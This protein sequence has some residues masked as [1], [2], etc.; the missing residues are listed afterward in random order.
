LEILSDL[1]VTN[2]DDIG[3]GVSLPSF[4]V[5]TLVM[6]GET[7]IIEFVADKIGAPESFCSTDH[8]EKLE[9]KVI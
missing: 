5:N 3:H 8:G 6:P 2:N 4:G 1:Y 9:I 7:K